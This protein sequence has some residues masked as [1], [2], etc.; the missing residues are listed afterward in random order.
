M[1]RKPRIAHC[2][3][4]NGS[5]KLYESCVGRFRVFCRK[6]KCSTPYFETEKEAIDTWNRRYVCYNTTRL[7]ETYND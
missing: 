1:K 6:C 2:P 4:C 3:F 7:E 5:S